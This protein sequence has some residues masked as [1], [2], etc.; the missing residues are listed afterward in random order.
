MKFKDLSKSDIEYVKHVYFE[1]MKHEQKMDILTKRF[2]TSERSVRRWWREKLQLTE[3]YTTL[4][5]QLIVP[6]TREL[7][8]NVD[9]VLYTSCQNK[10][11][12]NTSFLKN[13]ERYKKYLE[14]NKGKKVE[15]VIAPTRYRNPTSPTEDRDSNEEWWIPEIQQYLYYNKIQ[16]GDT[17]LSAN[18][19]VIPTAKEPL[20]SFEVLAKDNNLVLPHSKIHFK[21]LPRFKNK[22]LRIMSTTGYI[23]NKNYSD[24]KAGETAY[25]HHSYGFVIIEK[26]GNNTC[27]IPRNVKVK[28]DGSFI[29]IIFSVNSKG[30]NIIDSSEGFVWGD[31]HASVIDKDV[32]KE[33]IRIK[34]LLKPKRT[35]LHDVFDGATLN[36]HE[37]KDMY[38]Q[39]KKIREGKHLIENEILESFDLIEDIK[40]NIGGDIYVSLSNHDVF[41]DRYINDHNWKKDLHNSHSYLKYAHIQQ[42][43]DME[44]HGSIYGYLL[45]E[46]FDGKVK[47]LNYGSSL[48]IKGYECALHGDNGT[49]GSKGS[50]KQFS[51]LNTKMI[52]GHQ[53]SPVMHN[54]VTV[55]GVT[56]M[57]N[58]YYNRKGI[59]S[60]AFGHSVIHS[61][62]KNQLLVLSD[63]KKLSGLM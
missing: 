61:N 28:D 39:K 18:S 38:I 11:G 19:R 43:E 23:S 63:D 60:W 33:T 10:T 15:I 3:E 9:V 37:V 22:P 34:K 56:S 41:L 35:V 42:T 49:N 14:E 46:R 55:V 51:R 40:N 32:Y 25:L 17:I 5:E 31:I 4:P 12:I 48:D 30:V 1:N 44:K 45:H 57:L 27:Y 53:H 21:T 36:P 20:T 7:P 54:S 58:Q 50:Y 2:G 8:Q 52:H 6:S 24:S 29:D 62:G 13:L 26:K 47:Y 16:F 59:S